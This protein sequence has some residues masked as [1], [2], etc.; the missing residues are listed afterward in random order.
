[1]VLIGRASERQALERLISGARIGQSGVLVITGEPGVGKTALL[2]YAVD[3]A[4]GMGL[5]R[6]VG[7]ESEREVP[8]GG[9]L[10]LLRPALGLLDQIPEP[11]ADALAAAL[12]LRPGRAGDRFAIG[13]GTLS[14]MCRY[15]EERPLAIVI[16]DLPDLDRPSAQAVAFAAHRLMADPIVLF[17]TARSGEVTTLEADLPQLHLTG[18]D[19]AA[20]GELLSAHSG[21]NVPSELV[22]RLHHATSGNPLALIELA[23][24]LENL[25][26]RSPET[27]FPVS[28]ALARSF[29]KR[30]GDLSVE[31]RS[32]LLVAATAGADLRTVSRACLALGLDPATLAEAERA[33]LTRV[34]DDRIEFR[35]PLIRLSVY[36]DAP[37]DLRRSVHRAVADALPPEQSD[38]RAWHLAESVLGPDADVAER[39]E[40]AAY[41]ARDRSAH[42]VAS[43]AYERAARLSPDDD[44]RLARFVSAAE[45]AWLAGSGSRAT[46]L[47]D[48]VDTAGMPFGSRFL[49]EVRLR[50]LE[51]R[52]AIATRTG[53]LIDARDILLSAALEAPTAD[54]EVRLLADAI[55]ACFYLGDAPSALAMARQIESLE[56]AVTTARARA[57]G[58]T[59]AGVGRILANEGGPDQLRGAV[60]MLVSTSDPHEDER[61]VPW[62]MIGPLFLRDAESGDETRRRIDGLRQEAAVG[63]LPFMLFN[64]ARDEAATDRWPRA[65]A[66]YAEGIRLARETG[67][68]TDLAMSQAGLA[69]LLARQGRQDECRALIAEAMELSMARDVRLARIWLLFAMG[70]LELACGNPA[71]AVPHFEG[72]VALLGELG[73]SDPDLSPAADL[74][75]AL[76]HVGRADEARQVASG[77][78]PVALAKARPWAV[79]RAHRAI[80]L[81]G[82]DADLDAHF[83][84]ALTEHA[85]T[86]DGYETARTELAYGERLRRARRRS[87]ARPHLRSALAIFEGLR[88]VTWADRAAAELEA[89]GETAR[90]SAEPNTSTLTPQ[91]LQISLLLAEGKTTRE[92]AAALFLSPKTVEYHLRKVYTKLGIRSRTEL[93]AAL[94]R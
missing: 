35:H 54:A 76:V 79:A 18:I 1:M 45:S 78:M 65:E 31:A 58:A 59:A 20:S 15:A 16:D 36:S 28:A 53:S 50:A 26:R 46:A 66:T 22:L 89:T 75:E 33:L 74:V 4:T 67:Q 94:P 61:R 72:L 90:R 87:D 44:Q 9:L 62:L 84:A 10:Q 19:A 37:P 39:L 68:T 34:V 92:V 85:Q 52:G 57:V 49:P 73:F 6:A 69:W 47:L 11:Q 55:Y 71:G 77:F 27:P 25:E 51:L 56:G 43:A 88:A 21:E 38:R 13:A 48:E 40:K 86:L 82:P 64:V 93:V 30:V 3:A 7:S 2:D 5:L 42:A 8:F 14:L 41:A 70:D 12:A 29:S 81:A 63:V 80:G 24:D 23:D 60:E 91:E 32:T 17:A 83:G